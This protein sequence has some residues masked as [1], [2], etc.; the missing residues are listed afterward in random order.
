MWIWMQS[1]AFGP[2][3]RNQVSHAHS[4]TL[5]DKLL[6]MTPNLQHPTKKIKLH[7]HYLH[8]Q[9]LISGETDEKA[10]VQA[11]S[12]YLEYNI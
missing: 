9:Q 6:R 1:L 12:I 10:L 11:R 8:Q 5:E 3:R 2:W 7:A 4:L